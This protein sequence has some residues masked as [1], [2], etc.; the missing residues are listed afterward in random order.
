MQRHIICD[1]YALKLCRLRF[2]YIHMHYG[3]NP[4]EPVFLVCCDAVKTETKIVFGH[5]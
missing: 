2:P 1:L 3:G 4:D 5:R